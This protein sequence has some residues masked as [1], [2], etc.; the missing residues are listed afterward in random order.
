MWIVAAAALVSLM[1]WFLVSPLFEAASNVVL[2]NGLGAERVSLLDTKER[3]V[4]A[5]KD[6]E[7]DFAMGKVGAEDFEQSKRALTVEVASVLQK[8]REHEGR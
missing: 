7:L 8:L 4:R 2:G 5:L 1:A 3:A 6:L